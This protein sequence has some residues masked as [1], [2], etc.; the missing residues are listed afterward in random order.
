MSHS[1]L[2]VSP[3]LPVSPASPIAIEAHLLGRPGEPAIPSLYGRTLRLRSLHRRRR[4][5][6][7]A[8]GEHVARVRAE[9]KFPSVAALVEQIGRD[10]AVVKQRLGVSP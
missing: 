10:V 8:E 2:S 6:R 9:Q 5:P 7:S 1:E 4:L 3:V